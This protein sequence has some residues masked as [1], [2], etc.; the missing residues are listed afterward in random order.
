MPYKSSVIVGPPGTGKTNRIAKDVER[1]QNDQPTRADESPVI[2]C[3]LTKAAATEAKGRVN[4]PD[5]A[6]GTCH[7]LGWRSQGDHKRPLFGK[8]E[9]ELWYEKFPNWVLSPY[10][11][12]ADDSGSGDSSDLWFDYHLY[13][14]TM[15][16]RNEWH[17]QVEEF[18]DEWEK[19]K[20]DNL[21]CDFSDM[22]EFASSEAPMNATH[23]ICDEAQDM[24]R[25]ENHML[26][27]WAKSAGAL[28][29]VGDPLQSLYTW[30]GAEPD[31]LLNQPDTEVLEQSYRL[32]KTVHRM[33][34]SWAKALDPPAFKPTDKMGEVSWSNSNFM[35]P[36]SII[37]E[38]RDVANDQGK[39]VIIAA[40]CGY[41]LQHVTSEMKSQ[42]IPY[43]NK[44]RDRPGWNPLQASNKRGVSAWSRL[45]ALI[46]TKIHTDRLW[47]LSDLR[48]WVKVIR[49]DG[50]LVSGAKKAI[51]SGK[52][53]R[54][55]KVESLP[56]DQLI[57]WFTP[58][59][60]SKIIAMD[61]N[62]IVKWFEENLAGPDRA[63]KTCKYAC[64]VFLKYGLHDMRDNDG[65]PLINIGTCHSFKGA[66]ADTVILFPDI[67]Y[68]AWK[69]CEESGSMSVIRTIYVGMTRSKDRLTLCSPADNLYYDWP[70][71]R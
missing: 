26:S 34:V 43:G 39:T 48:K 32:P 41:M 47:S 62:G 49:A 11:E 27:E 10:L 33:A 12:F 71:S 29:R 59:C 56:F 50:I 51:L 1:I 4:L 2:V 70:Y 54:F 45:V 19:F 40:T 66:E 69:D 52:N 5:G 15:T 53:E 42:G 24:S 6:V 16:P 8:K 22:I 20:D 67:S 46:D 60:L 25:L 55:E 38:A 64:D 23:I 7:S 17:P 28:V 44:W 13:R 35:Y 30:R 61:A 21:V 31:L 63:S 3:S 9:I 18:A 58:E 36:N 65:Y 14:H 37:K 57:K 68:R